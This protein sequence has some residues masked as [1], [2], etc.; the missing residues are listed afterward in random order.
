MEV[1]SYL[2]SALCPFFNIYKATN[3]IEGLDVINEVQPDIVISDVMMPEMD[4]LTMTQK[5]KEDFSISHIPVIMLTAKSDINDQILGIETGAE[6]YL[7][8][9]FNSNQLLSHTISGGSR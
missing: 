3:G 1:L 9:P 7:L 5:I 6:A 2:E 8:K 4:G